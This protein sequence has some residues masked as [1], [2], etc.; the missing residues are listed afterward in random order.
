MLFTFTPTNGP[1]QPF[2]SAECSPDYQ[3]YLVMMLEEAMADHSFAPYT[4]VSFVP[5]E[6]ITSSIN[7]H[8]YVLYGHKTVTVLKRGITVLEDAL[9]DIDLDSL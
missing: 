2:D 5:Q 1:A 6:I 4:V 9:Q 3:A 7:E 8:G